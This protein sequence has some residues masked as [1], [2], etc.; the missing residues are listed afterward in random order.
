MKKGL[1]IFCLLFITYC[2]LL[3]SCKKDTFI[4]SSDATISTS[5][6]SLTYDTVFT[7]VGSITQSFK[8]NN[9]NDQ[10][11]RLSNVKLMGGTASPFTI[12]IN[13]HPLP[14]VNNIEI[15]ANDSIYVFVTVNIDPTTDNLPFIIEDSIQIEYNGNKKLV[16]LQAYGQNAIF[17]KGEVLSAPLTTWTNTLPYVILD[18]L[19]INSGA[20][21]R[22]QSGSKIY[23]HANAP[24]IV[25]GRLLVQGSKNNEVVFTGDRLDNDYKDLPAS[26]PGIY[27]RE[28][29]KDNILTYA[30]IKNAYQAI[31]SL[32]PSTSLTNSKVTLNR[33]IIDNAYDAG[34]L[35][36][37]SSLE[38]N[39]SL[40]SNCGSNVAFLFGGEY[41]LTN[42]TV[43]TY[44]NNYIEHKNPVLTVT[45]YNTIDEVN[46]LNANFINCIFWGENGS[47]KDEV[48][49]NKKGT[50][51]FDVAFT[52]CIYKSESTDADTF[53]N[54]ASK[55]N[56]PPLFDS[57]DVNKRYFD[58]H[59]SNPLAPGY[60]NG[61]GIPASFLR[62]LDF[63]NRTDTPD[64]GSYEKQ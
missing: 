52:N 6:D 11:L 61:T 23:F 48:F 3:T 21:L 29:S 57:I 28:T 19:K 17:L 59:I 60:N 39:N 26:W 7:S 40:I 50:G 14:E 16:K 4:T 34:I 62:D 44:G 47:V 20:T 10:K 38:A 18:S 55:K 32:L 5:V 41:N 33:C 49:V 30:K 54:P 1:Y 45:N 64:I 9:T 37:A 13:G 63:I 15:A 56:Q 2:L 22:I 31:V 43:A 35:C 24:L 8:I 51:V 42:C 58:F 25:D 53:F 46:D 36:V 12:N 27:F